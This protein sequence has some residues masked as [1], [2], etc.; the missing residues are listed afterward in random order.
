MTYHQKKEIFP[1]PKTSTPT[2]QGPLFSP[3]FKGA[4]DFCWLQHMWRRSLCH[5]CHQHKKVGMLKASCGKLC[6]KQP[7]NTA[8]YGVMSTQKRW[9]S[10]QTI[11]STRLTPTLLKMQT[12]NLR[13]LCGWDL[14]HCEQA[15]WGNKS[16]PDKDR[17]SAQN[18]CCWILRHE[19]SPTLPVGQLCS[20]QTFSLKARKALQRHPWAKVHS[21]LI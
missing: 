3:A 19:T 18:C 11:Y 2:R 15:G 16:F 8:M 7:E 1:G 12:Q 20:I 4:L 6:Q 10:T 9:V 5:W 14:K 17:P 21:A 13:N